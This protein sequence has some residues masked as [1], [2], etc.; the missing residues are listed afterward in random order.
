MRLFLIFSVL[1]T[2][3]FFTSDAKCQY[4]YIS[5]K[6]DSAAINNKCEVYLSRLKNGVINYHV[7]FPNKGFS[8]HC[9]LDTSFEIILDCWKS[10]KGLDKIFVQCGDSI[11]VNLNNRTF[12]Y[13]NKKQ[14]IHWTLLA[15]SFWSRLQRGQI[16]HNQAAH[17]KSMYKWVTQRCWVKFCGL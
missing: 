7:Y 2:S 8:F 10:E 12:S 14:E 11:L 9:P 13:I 6:S 17:N 4:I 3:L 1:I 5:F 16:L 15:C